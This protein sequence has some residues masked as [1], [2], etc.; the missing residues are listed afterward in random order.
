MLN[1]LEKVEDM[2]HRKGVIGA[3]MDLSRLKMVN[4]RVGLFVAG[5]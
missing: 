2:L 1:K 5:M 3:V 4:I